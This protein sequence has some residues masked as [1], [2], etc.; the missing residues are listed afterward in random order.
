M[1]GI[2]RRTFLRDTVA[3]ATVVMTGSALR[4]RAERKKMHIG[5]QLYSIRNYIP[6]DVAGGFAAIKKMGYEGVEFAGYYGKDAKNLR[7]LLDDSGLK[8]CGTHIQLP[9]LL[10]DQLKPTIEFNH[11]LGNR[12]L[13]VPAL[14]GVKTADDWRR[15]AETFN[16]I[17]A[18]LK[19][20]D[21]RLGYHNHTVEFQP[22]DGQ[23]PIDLFLEKASPDVFLQLDIG[24]VMRAGADPLDFFKKH[25]GRALTVHLKEY[26]ATKKDAVI[27]EGDMKWAEVLKAC[28][29]TGGTEWYIIE[30]ESGAYQG[31]E[32]IEKSLRGLEK[33]LG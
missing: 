18:Q 31:M 5:V 3:G 10:G 23:L 25:P 32:G 17:A 15:T 6:N 8:C 2:S 26:S 28:E 29:T 9:T 21:M 20:V 33:L 19:P 4:L 22:V 13:V 14:P 7:Q 16:Q 27:G 1:L 12:F 24:H 11:V 30:E